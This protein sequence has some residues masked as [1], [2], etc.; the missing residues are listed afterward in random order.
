[1]GESVQASLSF[2]FFYHFADTS[3]IASEG[4]GPVEVLIG[5]DSQTQK[6]LSYIHAVATAPF[7]RRI[8]LGRL[9]YESFFNIAR[10]KGRHKV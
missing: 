8:G 10:Q 5:F 3:L 7:H 2:R 9:L 6:D 1:M 4:G